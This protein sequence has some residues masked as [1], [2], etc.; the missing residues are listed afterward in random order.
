MKSVSV[1]KKRLLTKASMARVCF[2]PRSSMARG[3]A[4]HPRAIDDPRGRAAGRAIAQMN[5][6]K[7][8]RP[9]CFGFVS[10]V[11]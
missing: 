11:Y 7:A 1:Q 9:A 5:V 2:Y 6:D 10:L 3:C 8:S 4:F